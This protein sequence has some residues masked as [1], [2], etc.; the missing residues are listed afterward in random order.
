MKIRRVHYN[1]CKSLHLK[2]NKIRLTQTKPKP[3]E[4]GK[5]TIKTFDTD[6][7]KLDKFFDKQI[8]ETI[9]AKIKEIK[10]KEK[11]LLIIFM[12]HTLQRPLTPIE[13][14]KLVVFIK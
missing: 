6:I 13:K 12:E 1:D 5:P 10:E 4:E 3:Y 2:T 14:Q 8:T 7:I 9:L 11:E